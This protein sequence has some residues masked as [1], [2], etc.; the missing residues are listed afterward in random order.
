MLNINDTEKKIRECLTDLRNH[1]QSPRHLEEIGCLISE[2]LARIKSSKK[3]YDPNVRKLNKKDVKIIENILSCIHSTE[4]RKNEHNL[5]LHKREKKFQKIFDRN[6]KTK[7]YT[8]FSRDGVKRHLKKVFSESSSDKELIVLHRRQ[9]KLKKRLRKQKAH[10]NVHDDLESVS[11]CRLFMPKVNK[12]EGTETFDNRQIQRE[13][14]VKSH[15]SQINKELINSTMKNKI[16]DIDNLLVSELGTAVNLSQ[17]I[18]KQLNLI[19]I[20][21]R[22]DVII[23]DGFGNRLNMCIPEVL[24]SSFVHPTNSK[25]KLKKKE[26]V[27]KKESCSDVPSL[28]QCSQTVIMNIEDN[29]NI[30]EDSKARR[31]SKQSVDKSDSKKS[32]KKKLKKNDSDFLHGLKN[33]VQMK[34]SNMITKVNDIKSANGFSKSSITKRK[35]DG[36]KLKTVSSKVEVKNSVVSLISTHKKENSLK[37]KTRKQ[38][39]QNI[40][41]NNIS[42]QDSVVLVLSDKTGNRCRKNNITSDSF[43]DNKTSSLKL[44]SNNKCVKNKMKCNVGSKAGLKSSSK[45]SCNKLLSSKETETV[46]SEKQI[47]Q[48]FKN[49]MNKDTDKSVSTSKIKKSCISLEKNISS[50]P[51]GPKI[52]L[53]ANIK[54]HNNGVID[55]AHILDLKRNKPCINFQLTDPKLTQD[56]SK[57]QF[58]LIETDGKQNILPEELYNPTQIFNFKKAIHV[59]TNN[60]LQSTDHVNFSKLEHESSHS[61]KNSIDISINKNTKN[62]N[63]NILSVVI[64]HKKSVQSSRVIQNPNKNSDLYLLSNKINNTPG[65]RVVPQSYEVTK[66]ENFRIREN[67]TRKNSFNSRFS[68]NMNKITQN[69]F[70]KPIIENSTMLNDTKLNTMHHQMARSEYLSNQSYLKERPF[71]RSQIHRLNCLRAKNIN[72]QKFKNQAIN[73]RY[74]KNNANTKHINKNYIS[75]AN[76]RI[77]INLT[78]SDCKKSSFSP[79][80]KPS[81]KLRLIRRKSLS[82]IGRYFHH[83]GNGLMECSI[84]TQ[85]NMQCCESLYN[86]KCNIPVGKFLFHVDLES[87]N[88]TSSLKCKNESEKNVL[89]IKNQNLRAKNETKL[90]NFFTVIDDNS[91]QFKQNNQSCFQNSPSCLQSMQTCL[92]E[93]RKT[94]FFKFVKGDLNTPN[95]SNIVNN[96]KPESLFIEQENSFLKT[97]EENN[98]KINEKSKNDL[99]FNNVFN[100]CLDSET[101]KQN[102]IKIVDETSEAYLKK[103]TIKEITNETPI[104]HN[105]K[106]NEIIDSKSVNDEANILN[107]FS[108]L[109]F[110]NYKRDKFVKVVDSI[111]EIN[112]IS[113][114]VDAEIQTDSEEFDHND[115]SRIQQLFAE[116]LKQN[117]KLF[118]R[119]LDDGEDEKDVEGYYEAILQLVNNLFEITLNKVGQKTKITTKTESSKNPE[120]QILSKLNDIVSIMQNLDQNSKYNSVKV[121]ENGNEG[122]MGN[123]TIKPIGNSDNVNSIRQTDG[124]GD[125]YTINIPLMKAQILLNQFNIYIEMI[126]MLKQYQG[127]SF[128]R[129][130]TLNEFYDIINSIGITR[131]HFCKT[132]NMENL[133]LVDK[134]L[135]PCKL[136]TIESCL[137]KDFK[138]PPVE[139][140]RN[141]FSIIRD[142][143]D[144]N[145]KFNCK[146]PENMRNVNQK[147]PF[148]VVLTENVTSDLEENCEKDV[149]NIHNL[150]KTC[151]K[152]Y[153]VIGSDQFNRALSKSEN[154]KFYNFQKSEDVNETTVEM[155]LYNIAKS[156]TTDS[157]M[158]EFCNL[159][160]S[161]IDDRKLIDK[162]LYGLT[163]SDDLDR[164]LIEREFCKKHKFEDTD[165]NLAEREF[166]NFSKYEGTDEI[167]Q[168]EFYDFPESF[169]LTNHSLSYNHENINV[170][171]IVKKELSSMKNNNE[172]INE[173]VKNES[174]TI[175]G[176]NNYSLV[177]IGIQTDKTIIQHGQKEKSEGN[178]KH[179]TLNKQV[180]IEKINEQQDL[181]FKNKI[182]K[183]NKPAN[184]IFR[185]DNKNYKLD[186]NQ[187]NS[188]FVKNFKTVNKFDSSVTNGFGNVQNKSFIGQTFQSGKEKTNERICFQPNK[189]PILNDVQSMICRNNLGSFN[190]C[191]KTTQNLVPEKLNSSSNLLKTFTEIKN[192]N[193]KLNKNI[194]TEANNFNS[195]CCNN[196]NVEFKQNDTDLKDICNVIQKDDNSDNC[197]FNIDEY[198]NDILLNYD[199]LSDSDFE[200]LSE[201][202]LFEDS[203]NWLTIKNINCVQSGDNN[204]SD[205]IYKQI[206]RLQMDLC[207]ND[208][209]QIE[210][211]SDKLS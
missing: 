23:T 124:S 126:E 15:K 203:S 204:S 123:Q 158:K 85:D 161:Q 97:Q 193:F 136:S 176:K 122:D 88:H 132:C 129:I 181:N 189:G 116:E 6:M 139:N 87:N 64:K 180:D 68:Q 184:I 18:I 63:E 62:S 102:F 48:E 10:I 79:Y 43:S 29:Q 94:N 100:L 91:K 202:E 26:I 120:Y 118:I 107:L 59:N 168:K 121:L 106:I 194:E 52:V 190:N 209:L 135:P 12:D 147:N 142:E 175:S 67:E 115:F 185:K 89:I 201:Q 31:N 40:L 84:P 22:P 138:D 41:K 2:N 187:T 51:G 16:G 9:P 14:N 134:N 137:I 169:N 211:S 146:N 24:A 191:V 162:E 164:K 148:F 39:K 50:G 152:E 156:E 186:K 125:N 21:N 42:S 86:K 74:N 19:P 101:K 151:E 72:R 1:S 66:Q 141:F 104:K 76:V 179:D 78:H 73:V 108:G 11:M 70:K 166:F 25:L 45:K 153:K 170:N 188:T 117:R 34:M 27:D 55:S 7:K 36:L 150:F 65:Y 49:K 207:L 46:I 71:T 110:E 119:N 95:I 200:H 154:K 165:T 192:S 38:I 3:K 4:E 174:E 155:K 5:D 103:A 57:V 111:N 8:K 35:H 183:D 167:T 198:K 58:K 47:N 195:K 17:K 54:E 92:P 163:K 61:S 112:E 28:L 206:M 127:T 172:S 13:Q 160:K 90:N 143:M 157:K 32:M 178:T 131:K 171:T 140:R 75:V 60:S 159:A 130:E 96:Q 93:T 205:N 144:D 44:G 128:T 56:N 20:K 197:S 173:K 81:P 82:C 133:C 177:S 98:L 33:T 105:V 196:C 99:K 83:Q 113:P 145:S 149:E 208:C 182:N 37:R 69:V 210:L 80:Q 109:V 199:L 53:E 114:M 30:S 77:P